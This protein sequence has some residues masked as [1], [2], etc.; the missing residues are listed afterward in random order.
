MDFGE[1]NMESGAGT[2][3]AGSEI[4]DLE[5][6]IPNRKPETNA[7]GQKSNDQTN[8]GR[9]SDNQTNNDQMSIDRESTLALMGVGHL[10]LGAWRLFWIWRVG[11]GDC[12][13][14]SRPDQDLTAGQ[15]A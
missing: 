15:D 12:G 11:F 6:Q 3:R 13:R 1:K 14:D 9:T 2:R 8:N 5:S 7:N 4:S 10:S